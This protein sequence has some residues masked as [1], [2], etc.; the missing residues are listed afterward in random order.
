MVS[1]EGFSSL[2]EAFKEGECT[3]QS[4]G[5]VL[6]TLLSCCALALWASDYDI[7]AFREAGELLCLGV[8]AP[9]VD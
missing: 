3:P 7:E 6:I 5:G 9:Q 4:C 1:P 8:P 2:S